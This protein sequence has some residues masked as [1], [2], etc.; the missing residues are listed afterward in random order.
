MDEFLGD[1]VEGFHNQPQGFIVL[2]ARGRGRLGSG[3]RQ[4]KGQ[5]EGQ[6]PV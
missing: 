5:K 6:Y 3:K 2:G 4:K 1:F